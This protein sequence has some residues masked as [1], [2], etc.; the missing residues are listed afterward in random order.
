MKDKKISQ[1]QA[2]EK[3]NKWLDKCPVAWEEV[4][5]PTSF[6]NTINFDFTDY[7]SEEEEENRRD[8]KRGLYSQYEDCSN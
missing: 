5:H 2:Y 7:K 1:E 8:E 3:W 4:G 6:M